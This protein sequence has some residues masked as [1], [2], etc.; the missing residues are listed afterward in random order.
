MAHSLKAAGALSEEQG[1]F[2][3]IDVAA[4]KYL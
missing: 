3:S 1:S 2:P 4:Q